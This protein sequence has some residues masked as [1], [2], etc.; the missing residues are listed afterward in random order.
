MGKEN[1]TYSFK[2]SKTPE[3]IFHVLLDI[4]QWWSGQ[5]GEVINGRS[6]KVNDE[7]TFNAGGEAHYSKQKLIELIP[8]KRVVWQ[9]VESKLDFL[10][11]TGE[12][13][14]TSFRFDIS[15]EGKLTMVSFTHNGLVPQ[16]ECYT[17][18]SKGWAKYLNA[19]KHKLQ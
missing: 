7:F 3:E 18:C 2:S 13:T 14:G 4:G 5:Y 16:I 9:V 1:F 15:S 8:D 10:D 19:L 6:Q 12:W 11:N 17:E